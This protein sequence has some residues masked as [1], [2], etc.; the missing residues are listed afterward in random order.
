MAARQSEWI[1]SIAIMIRHLKRRGSPSLAVRRLRPARRFCDL[2]AATDAYFIF[3]S[4]SR[5]SR[6]DCAAVLIAQELHACTFHASARFCCLAK[7]QDRRPT[8]IRQ[9]LAPFTAGD[10]QGFR[11]T[12]SGGTARAVSEYA[13]VA[14]L[15][16]VLEPG[17]P[18]PSPIFSNR[19]PIC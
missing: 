14:L 2:R 5:H 15:Q 12:R 19:S 9:R 3:P 10:L 6:K 17:Q 18:N 8:I 13:R 16:L 4:S 1:V 7:R 11:R